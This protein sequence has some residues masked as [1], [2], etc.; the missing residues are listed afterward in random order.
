MM[1]MST[2]SIM[3][4]IMFM[5]VVMMMVFMMMVF[6]V[7]VFLCCTVMLHLHTVLCLPELPVDGALP[8]QELS[9]SPLLHHSALVQ[10]QDLVAVGHSGQ[11]MRD[12]DG[13][14]ATRGLLQC[15]HNA[16]LCDGVQ[17]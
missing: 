17:A 1:G 3:I 15:L 5:M 8:G 16:A 10:H 4:M 6:M 13:G 2:S 14:A 11:T 7:M 12:N 9:V